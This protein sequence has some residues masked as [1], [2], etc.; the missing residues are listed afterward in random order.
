MFLI[1]IISNIIVIIHSF[2]FCNMYVHYKSKPC[3]YL[4]IK[5]NH[6]EANHQFYSDDDTL[7]SFGR[8]V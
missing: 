8:S 5:G 4:F 2:N 7:E 1:S 3:T 6:P